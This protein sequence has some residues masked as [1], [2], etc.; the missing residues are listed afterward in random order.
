MSEDILGSFANIPTKKD[1]L[2]EVKN[3]ITI[4]TNQVQALQTALMQLAQQTPQSQPIQQQSKF[5]DIKE[6][7][8]AMGGLRN[9][10]NSVISQYKA[11]RNEVMENI[12]EEALEPESAEDF[13]LKTLSQ[14]MLQKSNN[15]QSEAQQPLTTSTPKKTFSNVE[16]QPDNVIGAEVKMD[17]KEVI[18]KLPE[19]VKEGIKSG[20]LSLEQCKAMVAQE[21]KN[22]GVTIEESFIEKVYK[23]V[24]N[25][26]T[27]IQPDKKDKPKTRGSRKSKKSDK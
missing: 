5:S 10:E 26:Q 25:E 3:S 17:A 15:S 4:L 11:L 24:R 9:Y 7:A 19:F 27:N 16:P 2:E 22:K 1:D 21:I 18:S 13:F 20:E 8:E 23:E 14:S 6:F 12:S